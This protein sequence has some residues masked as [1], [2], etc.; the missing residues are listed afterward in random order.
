M[1]TVRRLC[2]LLRCAAIGSGGIY[3]TPLAVSVRYV[4]VFIF[5]GGLLRRRGAGDLF[6]NMA[7]AVD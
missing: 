4:F 3:T 2:S 1:R 5:F 6:V 7:K